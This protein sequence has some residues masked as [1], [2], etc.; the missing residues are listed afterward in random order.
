MLAEDHRDT[1][2][3]LQAIPQNRQLSRRNFGA[4][5]TGV[6]CRAVLLLGRGHCLETPRRIGLQARPETPHFSR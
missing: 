5:M 4:E 6:E 2:P 1:L 3:G